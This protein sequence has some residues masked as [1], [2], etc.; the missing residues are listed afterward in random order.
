MFCSYLAPHVFGMGEK[1]E[2]I[3]PGLGGGN[4]HH[5]PFMVNLQTEREEIVFQK[6]RR[7]SRR[8]ELVFFQLWMHTGEMNSGA[9]SDSL[10]STCVPK[11]K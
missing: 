3:V 2:M 4:L 10:H 7:Y 6:K 9:H 8:E 11:T 5:L 1:C